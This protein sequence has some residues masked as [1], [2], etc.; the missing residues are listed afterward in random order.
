MTHCYHLA[1]IVPIACK[2]TGYDLPWDDCLIPI[3]PN[4][5]AF[6]NAVYQAAMAGCETIWL[7]CPQETSPVVRKRIGDFIYDPSSVGSKRFSIAPDKHRKLIPI[8]YVPIKVQNQHKSACLPWSIIRGALVARDISSSI[9]KWTKPD[10]YF[11]S[12]PYGIYDADAIRPERRAISKLEADWCLSYKGK[13]FN[14][15]LHLSYTFSPEQLTQCERTFMEHED[16]LLLSDES[17]FEYYTNE[18]KISDIF[19]DHEE[20]TRQFNIDYF[21]Q[22]DSWDSYKNYLSSEQS[23]AL[24]VPSKLYLSYS[25]W[26]PIAEDLEDENME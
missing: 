9:S 4:Y 17:A 13:T 19:R 10:K 20:N 7:V 15:N 2:P 25:E 21:S 1:G 12:F 14:D 23:S 3:A 22:I 26:N 11:V 24:K 16:G 6:E 8:Y 18:M 5:F